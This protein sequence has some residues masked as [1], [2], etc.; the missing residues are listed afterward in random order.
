MRVT[1]ATQTTL[2]SAL[3]AAVLVVPAPAVGGTLRIEV[4]GLRSDRGVVRAAV[5]ARGEFLQPTCSHGGATAAGSGAVVVDGVPD[6]TWA[7]Q[8]FH[9]EDGDGDLDRRGLRPAEGMGFSRDARMRF[10]PPRFGDA[11]FGF[12]GDATVRLTMRYFQ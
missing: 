6:G 5:C 2:R 7:V 3:V 1:P 9:D 10:G 4:D 8:V 11:A 12:A